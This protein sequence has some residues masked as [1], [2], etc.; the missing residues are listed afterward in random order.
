MACLLI[1]GLLIYIQYQ[2]VRNTYKLTKVEY[3]NEIKVAANIVI[4]KEPGVEKQLLDRLNAIFSKKDVKPTTRQQ[5]FNVIVNQSNLT[6]LSVERQYNNKFR[7]NKLLKNLPY[8]SRYDL[9]NVE[10]NGISYSLVQAINPRNILMHSNHLLQ[11]RN[12]QGMVDEKDLPFNPI[13]D[14]NNI[15]IK[16]QGKQYIDVE[17]GQ[18]NI[19]KRMISTFLLA[20][21]FLVAEII[22]FYVMISAILKQ[23]RLTQ[24]QKD[25]TDN[26]THE[27]KTPLSSVKVMFKSLERNEVLENPIHL[28]QLLQSL[29]RQY[30][31]IQVIT[32][33]VLESA[34][35]TEFR[36]ELRSYDINQH[37][38]EYTSDLRLEKHS[39]EVVIEP[40]SQKLTTN[41]AVL[42]K[43]LDNLIDNA[44]KYSAEGLKVTFNAYSEIDFYIIKIT[45]LGPG[46][47]INEQHRV[48]DKF[49]RISERNKHAIKGLG[50]GLYI[51]QQAVNQ[52]GGSINLI[53]KNGKGCTFTIK[54]PLI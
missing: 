23:K 5:L 43:A 47:P 18:S 31:K 13:N 30:E 29:K 6:T 3:E 19:L 25:F 42:D 46:I 21:G 35:V 50:L 9:F 24:I 14:F 39:L 2:L 16:F 15:K 10:L 53:S 41:L 33:S 32:D 52:L 54:L 37:L 20:A 27:L 11:V 34:M 38:R 22:L 26:I 44:I 45:D 28:R 4:D 51:S 40:T 8:L 12:F 36:P 17:S 49:Y 1:V 7:L 48:F